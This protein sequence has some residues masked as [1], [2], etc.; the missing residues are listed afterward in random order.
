MAKWSNSEEIDST[1]VIE[2]DYSITLICLEE[3]ESLMI[4]KTAINATLKEVEDHLTKL[5]KEKIGII[6]TEQRVD[7]LK[8]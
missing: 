1:P 3:T 8:K 5:A 2:I 4:N 7:L 6:L